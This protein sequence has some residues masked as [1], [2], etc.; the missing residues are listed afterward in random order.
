MAFLAIALQQL[1]VPFVAFPAIEG[2]IFQRI[3]AFISSTKARHVK[4]ELER[5]AQLAWVDKLDAEVNSV[6]A[7]A[8]AKLMA[9]VNETHGDVVM[10]VGSILLLKVNER[11]TLRTLAPGEMLIIRQ[12]PA[13][14]SDPKAL[15]QRLAGW[16][17]QGA[18]DP[19]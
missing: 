11:I 16:P 15:S 12:D 5:A 1:D 4:E 14:L 17:P 3:V 10:L 8:V 18:E 6:E 19:R 2:S 13:I 7:D 9:A